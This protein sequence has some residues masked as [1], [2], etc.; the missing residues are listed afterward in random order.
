MS[1]KNR[2][3]RTLETYLF[4]LLTINTKN[5]S[6]KKLKIGWQHLLNFRFFRIPLHDNNLSS[7]KT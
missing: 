6:F 5:K 1:C 2:M 4:T 3:M 7:P